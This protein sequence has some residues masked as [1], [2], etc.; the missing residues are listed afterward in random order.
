[1][2]KIIGIEKHAGKVRKKKNNRIG[3]KFPKQLLTTG[4]AIFFF[5]FCSLQAG[6]INQENCMSIYFM[7]DIV[8]TV[9]NIMCFHAPGKLIKNKLVLL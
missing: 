2:E 3:E 7:R 5:E 6:F 1:M 8:A 4:F 9:D